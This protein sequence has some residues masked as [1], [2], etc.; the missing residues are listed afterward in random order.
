MEHME[1]I[2]SALAGIASCKEILDKTGIGEGIKSTLEHLKTFTK[3]L[4][5]SNKVAS[6]ALD[7]FETDPSDNVNK[8]M[9]MAFLQTELSTKQGK[10]D[11]LEKIIS[12]LNES[13]KGHKKA[14]GILI[15]NSK[16][17]VT[18]GFKN[19]KGNISLGDVNK[20]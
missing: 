5:K 8:G 2:N 19:I 6:D 12:E 18:G 4:F 3:D 11:E 13:I 10:I 17:V 1:I 20:G 14:E 16:N 15:E 9:L 7:Q